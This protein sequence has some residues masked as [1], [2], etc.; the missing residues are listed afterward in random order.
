MTKQI[1]LYLRS[2]SSIAFGQWLGLF[3][4]FFEEKRAEWICQKTTL[5]KISDTIVENN[6]TSAH[7]LFFP[8]LWKKSREWSVWTSDG[9]FITILVLSLPP[10]PERT[11]PNLPQYQGL[12]IRRPNNFM[13]IRNVH[14]RLCN[15][16]KLGRVRRTSILITVQLSE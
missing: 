6:K 7:T 5:R 3:V 10:S 2:V 11:W 13:K 1:L 8:I 9:Y 4:L 16:E 14:Q 12:E 15:C